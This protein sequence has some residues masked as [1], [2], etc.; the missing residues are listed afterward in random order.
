LVYNRLTDFYF[1]APA[2]RVLKRA[3]DAQL[4]VVSPAPE[5][6]AS[7]ADKRNL[8]LLA[9]ACLAAFGASTEQ[10]AALADVPQ[11]MT[12]TQA[13]ADQLW[14]ERK[15]LFFKP[16]AGFGSRAVYR[17][18]KLTRK[19]W[20]Q[21]LGANYLAQPLVEPGRRALPSEQQAVSGESRPLKF[22]VRLY[23]YR[24][25]ALLTTARLYR[26]QTTNFRTAGGGFAPVVR[27]P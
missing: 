27:L 9:P 22:D 2:Q 8:G 10:I 13:A 14:A 15:G 25:E 17:G 16:H 5:H 7:Y 4:A 26:G 20:Q 23:T 12:V 1:E 21:M 18:S 24:G 19:V 3:H 11:T 6:H